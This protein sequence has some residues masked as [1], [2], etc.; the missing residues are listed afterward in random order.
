MYL[1]HWWPHVGGKQDV[2]PGVT[3]QRL[4]QSRLLLVQDAKTFGASEPLDSPQEA[5]EKK[6]VRYLYLCF[7]H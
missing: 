6:Y 2:G 1:N 7:Y 5:K 4:R 3:V